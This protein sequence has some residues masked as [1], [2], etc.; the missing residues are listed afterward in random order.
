MTPRVSVL[1]PVFNGAETLP[2]ALRSIVW[3]TLREW[4]LVLV[5][6]GSSDQSLAVARSAAARDP[7][8]RVLPRGHEGLVASLQAGLAECRGELVARMDA[9]DIA[10]PDRLA[11]QVLFLETHPDVAV[12]GS[13]VRIFPTRTRTAGMARYESWLNSLLEPEAMERELLVESPLVHPSVVFRRVAIQAVGGYRDSRGP[14]DYDLWLRLYEAGARFGKVPEVLLFWRDAPLRV[15]RTDPRCGR[16]RFRELKLDFLLRTRLAGSQPFILWGAGPNGKALARELAA[17]SR[18]ARAFI[19]S[20]PAR[21]GQEIAGLPVLGPEQVP[22]PGRFLLLSTVGHP[23]A[24]AQ[25]RAYLSE[26]GHREGRDFV[27]LT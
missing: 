13:R 18:P 2:A 4:E 24:R 19:D 9:D 10:H 25:I 6:D 14:E 20:H 1:L 5:D 27:C 16:E 12:V 26:R 17:R 22:P 8:I 11:R 21:R 3:Q 7:R 15:T 23:Q